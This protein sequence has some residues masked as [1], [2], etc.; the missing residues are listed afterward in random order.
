MPA[1]RTLLILGR[2]SNLPT[3]WS[4]CL[5][6]WLLCGGGAWSRLVLVCVS[7][8]LLY[9]GG[10][11]L[12]DACDA[13]FDREFRKER[14][15]PS[16]LISER[17]VQWLG[18]GWLAGGLALLGLLGLVTFYLGLL[19]VNCIAVYDLVHKR[20][21]LSPVIMAGCRVLLC[22][23]AGS[24]AAAG[25]DGLAVWGAVVLGAYIVGLSY[26]AKFESAPGALR[27]WPCAL[28]AAPLVL[29]WI[30][31][32]GPWRVPGLVLSLLLLVWTA[33]CLRF[34]FGRTERNLGRTVSGLLAGIV[35]VDLLAVAG[36]GS[37]MMAAVFLALFGLALLFQRHVPAT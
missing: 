27:Y 3:V 30:V 29:A 28:L 11:Y 17:A 16:G 25:L 5:A 35:L 7:A 26:L 31:N 15:I 6:A 23:V 32:D 12:N 34:T 36:G 9:L 14:P 8:T 2:V 21:A 20:T 24:A 33:R 1:L 19:L 4:N 22:L 13:A 37:P 10:M 18:I